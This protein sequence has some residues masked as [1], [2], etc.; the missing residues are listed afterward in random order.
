MATA[1]IRQTFS[2]P[3]LNSRQ[4]NVD[5][6]ADNLQIWG[7]TDAPITLN[8]AFVMDTYAEGA[9]NVVT[10]NAVGHGNGNGEFTCDFYWQ[11]SSVNK[12]RYGVPTTFTG[13]ALVTTNVGA[14]DDF[15][16]SPD[17]QPIL[18][19]QKEVAAA[20]DGDEVALFW[21]IF[22]FANVSAIGRSHV[23]YQEAADTQVGE[24]DVTGILQGTAVAYYD[25]E[26]GVSN[27]LTGNPIAHMQLSHNDVT[28]TPTF[29]Q[30]VLADSTA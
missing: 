13:D 22:I 20:I 27:P 6:S 7:G 26:G 30:M 11:E 8:G 14:G 25:I 18:C 29:E 9:A 23:D 1:T 21:A 16:T 3:G 28:Y 10:G 5:R 2:V 24:I 12:V 15:P 17:E 19:K 4:S